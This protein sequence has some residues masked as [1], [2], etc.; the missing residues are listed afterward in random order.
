MLISTSSTTYLKSGQKSM[1]TRPDKIC[2]SFLLSFCVWKTH[3]RLLVLWFHT[4]PLPFSPSKT[5]LKTFPAHSASKQSFETLLGVHRMPLGGACI[6]RR[7]ALTLQ[8]TRN[9]SSEGLGCVTEEENGRATNAKILM[10]LFK[11]R[12]QVHLFKQVPLCKLVKE[13]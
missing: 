8:V 13:L 6:L 3:S 1:N 11:C 10:E 9:A 5:V 4:C 12:D 7:N 2:T